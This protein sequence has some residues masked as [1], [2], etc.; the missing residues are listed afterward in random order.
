MIFVPRVVDVSH[1]TKLI[2]LQKT[3]DAGIW[4]IIAKC[5]QN[6]N[7]ID[8]KYKSFHTETLKT[9]ML[10]GGYHFG[11]GKNPIQQA[12]WFLKNA[13]FDEHTLVALDYEKNPTGPTMSGH[14]LVEFLSYMEKQLGRKIIIYSGNLLKEVLDDLS[15]A[16]QLYICSHKL[17]LAQYGPKAKLP[18]GFNKYFL[19][20]YTG[21]GIG[22][23]PHSV[24]GLGGESGGLD[25]NI[26][27][28]TR[29]QL[30][31]DWA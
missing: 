22:P 5:T 2:N 15:A 26:Y 1:W 14:Q 10:F 23:S 6:N 31:V 28:G 17:W 29:E 16:D 12:D 4:G 19:W 18:P 20:Q 24:P 27:D 30:T 7:Y 9:G 25:L 3:A 8:T 13:N 11:T 21:D